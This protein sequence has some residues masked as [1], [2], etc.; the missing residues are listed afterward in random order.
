M[1]WFISFSQDYIECLIRTKS[2]RGK[3]NELPEISHDQDMAS[4][5]WA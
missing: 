5:P 2:H 4:T 3:V 1:Q